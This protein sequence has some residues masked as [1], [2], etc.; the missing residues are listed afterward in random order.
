MGCV[1]PTLLSLFFDIMCFV[2]LVQVAVCLL[3]CFMCWHLLLC[4]PFNSF[5]CLY[6][7]RQA[8]G[9]NMEIFTTN[10]HAGGVDFGLFSGMK[11]STHP[12]EC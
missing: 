3:V 1:S 5:H 4:L 12:S 7:S 10:W 11:W 6:G 9:V 8:T 2:F